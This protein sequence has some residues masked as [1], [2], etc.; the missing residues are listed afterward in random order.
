MKKFRDI[1]IEKMDIS[2][3]ESS[4]E[5]LL[6]EF[7]NIVKK[8]GGKSV[9]RQLLSGMNNS[10][11]KVE[12][13]EGKINQHVHVDKLYA[14]DDVPEDFIEYLELKDKRKLIQLYKYMKR[15]V[16]KIMIGFK[17]Y[18][19]EAVRKGEFDGEVKYSTSDWNKWRQ[20]TIKNK[21]IEVSTQGKLDVVYI[22]N[23][24]I[25]TRDAQRGILMIDKENEKLFGN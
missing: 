7:R 8:L 16:Y 5:E 4:S 23:K 12:I 17:E 9:A 25:A 6:L 11:F 14:G 21:S 13:T 3:K 10:G 19:M 22:N 1:I 18:L 2:L 20:A 24:H 15:E